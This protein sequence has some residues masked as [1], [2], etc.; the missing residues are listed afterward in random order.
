MPATGDNIDHR[1]LLEL[2]II[3][4]TDAE[5]LSTLQKM[6]DMGW[7]LA[8]ARRALDSSRGNEGIYKCILKR[9]Q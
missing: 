6:G 1:K 4:P 5:L 2:A 8:S 7:D 3:T 9:K